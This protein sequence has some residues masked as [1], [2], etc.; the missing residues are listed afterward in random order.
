MAAQALTL[1]DCEDNVLA[2]A[3]STETVTPEQQ[4]QFLADFGAAL[5]AAA[6]KRDRVAHYLAH[7]E[8]QQAFAAQEIKRLIERKAWYERQQERLEGY[9]CHVIEA[10][11]LDEK[12]RYRKLEG[13]VSTLSVRQCP[14]TVNI[15]DE[16][17]VPADYKT[18]TV[19]LPAVLWEE[20]IGSLD[21][22]LNTKVLEAVKNPK[23]VI[24]KTAVKKALDAKE[25]VMGAEMA[26]G[27]LSLVRK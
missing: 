25:P 17:A 22:D 26:F 16:A 11:G 13:N 8:M 6:D 12:G 18:A 5:L 20:L 10:I 23:L 21:I 1:Y 4:E 24:S 3:E 9:V 19:S 14:D 7:L 2:L 15:T 27:K